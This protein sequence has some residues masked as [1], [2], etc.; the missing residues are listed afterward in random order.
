[1]IKSVLVAALSV[2]LISTGLANPDR[3][4]SRG[5]TRG[6]RNADSGSSKSKA[7]V[8]GTNIN[9]R[10]GPSPESSLVTKVGGAKGIVVAQ[11]GDWYK[12]RFQFG[13]TGW[14]RQ[15]FLKIEGHSVGKMIPIKLDPSP[16][17][18]SKITTKGT[19]NGSS[20]SS[21][22][23]TR[24]ASLVNRAVNIHRG[25]SASNSI[26]RRVRGGKA[27]VMDHRG[28]W[29][30][31][32]FQYGTR[33]WVKAESLVFPSNFDFKN[34]RPKNV[35]VE[36]PTPVVATKTPTKSKSE[37]NSSSESTPENTVVILNT[38]EK[39]TALSEDI[40]KTTNTESTGGATLATVIGDNIAVRK[41]PSKSNSTLTRVDGGRATI[42]DHRGEFYQLKFEHG[43]IGWV[44]AKYVSYPGHI[45]PEAPKLPISSS[46]PDKASRVISNARTFTGVRYS[47]GSMSRGATDCSGF[48]C[49]VF[50]SMGINL[51]RTARAQAGVGKRVSRSELQKGDL[52]FFNTL[53][54]ISHVGIYIG[55]SRFIHASSG[56]HK[57]TESSL[58]ERFYGKVF[59][60]G[61]RI[62]PA[63]KVKKLELPTPGELPN[64][65]NDGGNDDKDNKVDIV[66][67]GRD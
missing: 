10:S 66:G 61:T 50:H 22:V 39:V 20:A 9:V 47:Y 33:G 38:G 32:K 51:P 31:L 25:P 7:T 67:S 36:K 35:V 27:Q 49:Q 60:F 40:P 8:V 21:K 62:L 15:D 3:G 63:S 46:D 11:S 65:K 56:K 2:A 44:H 52:V 57:V 14:V 28:D 64:T 26:A 34:S 48:T 30:E 24:Y 16:V 23:M 45:I 6:H 54:F 42:I 12:I 19:P 18:V 58:N 4:S 13:T 1:L 17:L 55:D 37:I 59:L 53:G 29:F 43:T 41:G 5:Y